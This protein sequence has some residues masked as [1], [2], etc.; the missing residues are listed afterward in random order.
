MLSC[1]LHPQRHH[2]HTAG[3]TD[4]PPSLR[5]NPE[6]PRHLS[7]I[8]PLAQQ[9]MPTGIEI[10]PGRWRIDQNALIPQ[11]ISCSELCVQLCRKHESAK[12]RPHAFRHSFTMYLLE[13]GQD[14]RT[15]KELLGHMAV[16]TTMAYTHVQIEV[17]TGQEALRTLCS[18]LHSWFS[19]P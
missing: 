4:L 18:K 11:E 5:P 12:R 3:P 7:S 14:R 15:I 2:P 17:P 1:L 9:L 19:E 16:I 10:P 8:H 13:W 6:P